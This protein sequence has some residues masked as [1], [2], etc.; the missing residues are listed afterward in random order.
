[1]DTVKLINIVGFQTGWQFVTLISPIFVYLLLTKV[2]GI[3]MLETSAD[4][5]WVQMKNTKDTNEKLLYFYLSLKRIRFMIPKVY[6]T[7]NS[8]SSFLKVNRIAP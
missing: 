8:T 5:K 4:E 7:L 2:S 3:N 1:M 6:Q